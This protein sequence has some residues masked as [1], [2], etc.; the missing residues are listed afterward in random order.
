MEQCAFLFANLDS[1]KRCETYYYSYVVY[2]RYIKCIK[3]DVQNIHEVELIYFK[4]ENSDRSAL[5]LKFNKIGV[6]DWKSGV[7]R[8][9]KL[10]Y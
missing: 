4:Y 2:W 8:S 10:V 7:G 3:H 6:W 1:N 5:A 9:V